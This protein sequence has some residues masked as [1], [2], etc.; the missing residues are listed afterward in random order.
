[1]DLE[2]KD[3]IGMNV[4]EIAA[5]RGWDEAVKILIDGDIRLR[6]REFNK[7]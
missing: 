4:V 3:D 2:V 6:T 1:M 5:S 7:R